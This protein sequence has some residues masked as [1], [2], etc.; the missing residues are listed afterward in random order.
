[1]DEFEIDGIK[2]VYCKTNSDVSCMNV[3]FKVGSYSENKSTVGI[4]HFLEHLI[5]KDKKLS[6]LSEYGYFYDTKKD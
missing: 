4:S 6:L 5:M 3:F 2:V 1:M